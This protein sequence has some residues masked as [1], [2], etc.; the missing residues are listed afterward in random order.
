MFQKDS[1]P[2]RLQ[3]YAQWLLIITLFLI[4]IG[5]IFIYSSSAV[6]ALQKHGNAHYFLRKQ[7][8]SLS[9]AALS[10]L[11]CAH[12]PL[13]FW[14]HY[15]LPLCAGAL[16]FT[17]L[18]ILPLFPSCFALKIN[19]AQRWISI[20]GITMQPG[21]FLKFFLLLYTCTHLAN[22]HTKVTSFTKTLLPISI[23]L[24]CATLILLQQPDFGSV[25]TLTITIGIILF[26][27]GY[28]MFPLMLM[29]SFVT[30]LGIILIISKPYR[31]A[32][33]LT[34]FNP[35]QDP[36]GKGFQI[37]QALIAIGSGSWWGAG[38]AHSK[39]KFFYLPMQHTDFIFPII[40]EET[41][42]IGSCI[43]FMLYISFL[44]IGFKIATRLYNQFASLLTASFVIV[45]SLQAC[46]NFMVTLGLVPTKGLGLPFVSYGGS[47][48]LCSSAMIGCIIRAVKENQIKQIV[49]TR[50]AS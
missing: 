8:F 2:A 29:G 21:E 10:F 36:T 34:F 5:L 6:Y 26:I 35:W 40:A 25:V 44:I 13:W 47:S 27:I 28:D 31:L 18:T 30:L 7:F 49:S 23:P 38:I 48:L 17:A 45:I 32:R 43:L 16:G 22:R 20:Y 15:A 42:L 24:I 37:I 9:I 33:L 19:G 1:A 4:V 46:I 12:I 3:D 14:Q 11:V 50:H 39:Q 41:G